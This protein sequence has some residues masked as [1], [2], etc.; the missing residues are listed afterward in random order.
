LIEKIAYT[1]KLAY[2][3]RWT[4]F[5]SNPLHYIFAYFYRKLIY[6]I[7]KKVLTLLTPTFWG[8]DMYIHLP[9]STDIYLTR[10]KSHDSEIRLAKYLIHT[11]KEGNTFLDIGAH[12]GYFSMLACELVGAQGNVFAYEPSATSYALANKN[13]LTFKQAHIYK[14]AV[15]NTAE[16]LIFYEFPNLQS[17]YNTTDVTQFEN[18][19]WYKK[20]KPVQVEVESTTIDLITSS[21][22]IIPDLIKIDVEGA[23]DKVIAGSMNF[24]KN[25][26]TKV[27]MEFLSHGRGNKNHKVALSKLTSLGFMPHSINNEGHLE[28]INDVEVFMATNKNESDNIVFLKVK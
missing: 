3:S 5:I 26:T 7:N 1:E 23:E 12:Y 27:V 4:R 24:L 25:N 11:L 28:V 20:Q 14:M 21:E 17:E 16:P 22:S 13:L 8:K 9:A 15:S 6:P 19:N 2:G 18:E 10:G